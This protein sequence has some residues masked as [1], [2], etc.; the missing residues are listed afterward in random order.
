MQGHPQ[1]CRRWQ[2]VVVLSS[3]RR[4]A[5]TARHQGPALRTLRSPWRP[6]P[7]PQASPPLP[8]RVQGMWDDPQAQAQAPT[9]AEV[10]AAAAALSPAAAVRASDLRPRLSGSGSQSVDGRPRS[11]GTSSGAPSAA[12]S[13]LL[14]STRATAEGSPRTSRP[15]SRSGS[16]LDPAAAAP[17]AVTASPGAGARLTHRL[18]GSTRPE[19]ARDSVP[20]GGAAAAGGGEVDLEEWIK[21]TMMGARTSR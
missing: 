7:C 3:H 2:V 16:Q 20:S 9:P 12:V 21:Q 17:P 19:S 5:A 4:A 11:A 15:P 1:W 6:P 18:A 14:P 13:A 10:A 8:H